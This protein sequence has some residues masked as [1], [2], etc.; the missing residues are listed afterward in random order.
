MG[1]S[2]CIDKYFVS[3]SKLFRLQYRH[4]IQQNLF[5][6]ANLYLL[7]RFRICNAFYK[8]ANFLKRNLKENLSWLTGCVDLVL[9]IADISLTDQN[10]LEF[11]QNLKSGES[12]GHIPTIILSADAKVPSI[13]RAVEDRMKKGE[14]LAD[15]WNY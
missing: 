6:T 14:C 13:K 9:T 4:L 3:K 2:S 8:K 12:T 5:T 11:I 1:G 7:I 10:S 15:I